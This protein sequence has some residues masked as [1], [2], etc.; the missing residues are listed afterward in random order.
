MNPAIGQ[1]HD[2]TMDTILP[3]GRIRVNFTGYGTVRGVYKLE[4]YA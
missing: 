2:A 3:D 1:W 4:M